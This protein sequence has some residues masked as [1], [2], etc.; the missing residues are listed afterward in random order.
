MAYNLNL[1]RRLFMYSP[2]AENE[3]CISKW[4]ENAKRAVI[5]F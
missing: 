5:F 1:T 2:Q 4:L 3:F